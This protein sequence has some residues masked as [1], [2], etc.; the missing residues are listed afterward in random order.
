MNSDRRP[1]S[2]LPDDDAYWQDLAARTVVAAFSRPGPAAEVPGISPAPW[3]RGMS[4]AAYVLAASAALALIGGS[5][6][7][8]DPST[9]T[10]TDADALRGALAPEDDLLA[11]LLNADEPPPAAALLRLLARRE[12]ER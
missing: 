8:D 6:L 12:V 10:A 7:L 11:S 3:W 4:D 5:L 1:G 2:R 9:R